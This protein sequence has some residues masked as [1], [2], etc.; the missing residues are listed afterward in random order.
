T[1]S[2]RLLPPA[3][4]PPLSVYRRNAVAALSSP[5]VISGPVIEYAVA[6]ATTGPKFVKFVPSVLY[7]HW[8]L[9]KPVLVP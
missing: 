2:M 6:G 5:V 4:V 1:L 8:L 3:F 9:L 7:D